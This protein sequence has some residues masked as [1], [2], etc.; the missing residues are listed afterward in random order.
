MRRGHRLAGGGTADLHHH[1]RLA[2]PGRVVGGEHE[3]AAVLEALDVARDHA[4]LGLIREV[5]REV[6]E[7]EV[8]LVA[9][10]RPVREPDAD[11]LALEHGPAL[12]SRLGDQRDR[13]SLEIVAELLERVEVR[14]RPEQ[15]NVSRLHE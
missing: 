5:A 15:A 2:Q 10:R 8:D 7:L 13:R 11:L 4:D 12:V 3:R 14:V 1:H 9:G 6:G